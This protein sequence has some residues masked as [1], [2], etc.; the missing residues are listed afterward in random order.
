ME[1]KI[2]WKPKLVGKI[3]FYL[4]LNPGVLFWEKNTK[5]RDLGIKFAD[6]WKDIYLPKD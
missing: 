3:S 4:L 1:L 2:I 5:L 6:L